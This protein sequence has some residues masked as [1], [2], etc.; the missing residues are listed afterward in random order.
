MKLTLLYMWFMSDII[1]L[2]KVVWEGAWKQASGARTPSAC[3]LPRAPQVAVVLA[4]GRFTLTWC[5]GKRSFACPYVSGTLRQGTLD[6]TA[7]KLIY[8]K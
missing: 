1:C 4:V 2:C 3:A 8:T 5:A 6:F 7:H